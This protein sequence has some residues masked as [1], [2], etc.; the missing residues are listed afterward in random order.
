MARS[1]EYAD[2]ENTHRAPPKARPRRIPQPQPS[3]RAPVRSASPQPAEAARPTKRQGV[4]LGWLSIGLGLAQVL[5]P[6]QVARL[7]GA[8]EEDDATCVALRLVGGRELVCGV[9]L[10]SQSHPTAWAWGRVA[11]DVMDLALLGSLWPAKRTRNERLL[12]AGAVVLGVG[13]VDAYAALRGRRNQRDLAR[14]GLEV[15]EAITI[16]RPADEV[17]TFFRDFQNLPRF[18]SHLESVRVDNGH[19]HWCAKGPLGTR[20]EWDAEIVED[21]PGKH[22]V[23]RSV[24][25]ADIASQ[26][27]V[28]FRSVAEQETELDVVLRYD[29]PA[30]KVGAAFASLLGVAPS[31]QISSDLRR[32][33][34]V[35]ETGEVLHSDASIHRGMHPARPSERSL[36][37]SKKVRS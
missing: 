19:S 20:V 4:A 11:G 13:C 18:M 14:E 25:N 23:W 17:Y 1:E 15:R 9:G 27:R 3:H 35:L 26:G 33:K 30:G 2:V 29:P 22:I 5:A 16:A 7:I 34:Q 36:L 6:R 12:T 28:Q 37:V 10:L 31:Q 21:L 8:D 24:P 32:L